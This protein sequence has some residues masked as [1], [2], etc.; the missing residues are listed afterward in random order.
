MQVFLQGYGIVSS[1]YKSPY[2]RLCKLFESSRN[3][4]KNKTIEAKA[5]LK[6]VKKKFKYT[7]EKMQSLQA[8][9]AKLKKQ[10]QT[11]EL[12]VPEEKK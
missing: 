6:N 5:E 10:M 8:E 7:K 1:K 12:N 11:L 9:N 2:S 4:W 3:K